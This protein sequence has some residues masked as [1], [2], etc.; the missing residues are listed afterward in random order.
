MSKTIIY[1]TNKADDRFQTELTVD[2]DGAAVLRIGSNRDRRANPVGLFRTVVPG[3]LL[4]QLSQDTAS[5]AFI[6]SPSQ[7][8]LIPDESFRKITVI[9]QD[10]SQLVKLVGEEL[11]TPA[12]FAQ[13]ET[14]I[15]SIILHV[16]KFPVLAVA[17]RVTVFPE[18]IIAG[19]G[20][21]FDLVI[22]NVGKK[23]F[24]LDSPFTWGEQTTQG[25]LAAVRKDVPLAELSSTHQQFVPLGRGNFQASNPSVVGPRVDL[26]PGQ[27]IAI[28][29][30]SDFSWAPGQYQVDIDLALPLWDDDNK[31]LMQVGVVSESRTIAVSAK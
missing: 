11:A 7:A 19:Q 20:A 29:F 22:N 8:Q 14:T 27:G 13:A 28:R 21:L 3:H 9:G 31:L 5:P 23:A 30:Q 26:G 4:A 2:P 24:F 25:E 10:N 6:S 15:E 16:M 12:P 17:M 1:T 18:H